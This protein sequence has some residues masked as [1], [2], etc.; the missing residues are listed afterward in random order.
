MPFY[1]LSDGGKVFMGAAGSGTLFSENVNK[2]IDSTKIGETGYAFLLNEKGHVIMSPRS[3]HIIVSETGV[4]IGEDYLGSE[5]PAVREL[6]Q[7]MVA[8]GSGLAELNMDGRDV[9][10]A[11][12]PLNSIGWSLGVVAAI[13]EI[14]APARLIQQEILTITQ[15]ATADINR[16]LLVIVLAVAVVI[17]LVALVTIFLAIRLSNSLTA[18]ILSLSNG[19]KIISAGDLNYQLEVKTGDEVQMLAETFNKMIADIKHIT[20][21]KE[22]IGAELNVATTIQASMLPSTFPAFPDRTEFD[23]Y[24]IMHPA[25]EV[26]GDFYDFFMVDDDNLAVIVADVSG[27]GV[28]AAL[29]MVIAK[30]LLKNN[31]LMGTSPDELFYIVNNHLCENNEAR[32]NM[33]V[34][35]FMGLLTISTG[36]FRYVNAGHNP[37]LVKHKNGDF[38]WLDVK[39]GLMLACMEDMKF[40]VMEITL[41]KNDIV[42][43]YTDGVT[44]ALNEQEELFGN[45][46]MLDALNTYSMKQLPIQD[47]IA[48]MLDEIHNFAGKA[49]QADDIT[50]LM[51]QPKIASQK[52]A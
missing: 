11:Y 19:A 24:A 1:D 26:G 30:T 23:I 47:Y 41:D 2:I 48:V 17:I 35:A 25:K 5:N 3:E 44:E 20:G 31:A 49:E 38:I 39:A 43:M 29:F 33:F 36:R 10:V 18:P 37:P 21:E 45:N 14:I 9:Y 4:L 27:K 8:R 50:M 51:L 13:D 34:T 6:A 42:F 7:R 22:R 52:S 12:H 40:K 16:S 28:P 15:E 46:R 32:S